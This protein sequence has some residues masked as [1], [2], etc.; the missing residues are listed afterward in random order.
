[1][2]Y[3][4]SR[5]RAVSCRQAQAH[6][7]D[8]LAKPTQRQDDLHHGGQ[9]GARVAIKGFSALLNTG[10]SVVTA[11]WGKLPT[12]TAR[13]GKSLLRRQLKMNRCLIAGQ[14]E[15]DD[16]PD[17]DPSDIVSTLIAASRTCLERE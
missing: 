10:S 13:N 11:V 9:S 1:L 15:P 6:A 3:E 12:D 17:L 16:G 2:K 5:R 14:S 7:W 8:E 4:E